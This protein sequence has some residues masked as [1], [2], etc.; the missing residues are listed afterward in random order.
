MLSQKYIILCLFNKTILYDSLLVD[1]TSASSLILCPKQLILLLDLGNGLVDMVDVL[2]IG[3]L[4][5]SIQPLYPLFQLFNL[6]DALLD[7]FIIILHLFLIYCKNGA[8]SSVMLLH[9]LDPGR[10]VSYNF[11]RIVIHFLKY[12]FQFPLLLV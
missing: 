8:R 2:M 1:Y 12:L 6:I 10:V 11:N 5:L 7:N 4:A 3:R 9:F